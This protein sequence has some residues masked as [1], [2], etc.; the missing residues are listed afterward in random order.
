[1]TEDQLRSIRYQADTDGMLWNWKDKG[2]Q[3]TLEGQEDMEGTSCYKIKLV[4]EPGDIFTFYVDA[5]SYVMLRQNTKMMVMG[6]ESEN[7]T[8]F[9][10]YMMVDGITM[11]GKVESKMNGQLVMTLTFDKVEFNPELDDALFEKPAI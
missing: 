7:D 1:M 8:Y 3:V 4:T 9:S 11:P 6:N 5:D 10:N 2:Y